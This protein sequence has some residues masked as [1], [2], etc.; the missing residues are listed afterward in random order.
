MKPIKRHL[1]ETILCFQIEGKYQYPVMRILVEFEDGT[2]GIVYQVE[3]HVTHK[4]E[5]GLTR[6][7]ELYSE[8]EG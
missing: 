6:F 2:Q 5:G 1:Q 3:M 7:F 4:Q 8:N